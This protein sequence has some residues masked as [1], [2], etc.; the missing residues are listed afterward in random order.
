[1][2]IEERFKEGF[3]GWHVYIASAKTPSKI[4]KLTPMVRFATAPD[5]HR[6]LPN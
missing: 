4:P 5:F 1:M 6:K 2:F 3:K